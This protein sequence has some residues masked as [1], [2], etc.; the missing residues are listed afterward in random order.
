MTSFDSA[1][2]M[3]VRAFSAEVS[4]VSVTAVH[5]WNDAGKSSN[6]ISSTG[7]THMLY[8]LYWFK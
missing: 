3:A 6:K 5:T 1:V 8:T 7:D 4:N 2:T